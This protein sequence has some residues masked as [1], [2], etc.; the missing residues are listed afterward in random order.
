MKLTTHSE[1]GLLALLYICRSKRG[2]NIPLS[3]IAKAQGLPIKYM[4]HLMQAMCRAGYLASAKGKYGGY[5]L[6]RPA[7]KITVAE[8][9]RLFDGA[10]APTGSASRYFYKPT[11]IEKEKKLLKLMREIRDLIAKKLEHTTIADMC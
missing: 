1:Y 8:I 10:L 2:K 7:E 4:E 9:V 6:N 3:K 5:L 11:P